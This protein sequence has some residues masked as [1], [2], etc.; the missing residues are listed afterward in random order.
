MI[1][2]LRGELGTGWDEYEWRLRHGPSPRP[3]ALNRWDGTSL[4]GRS[5]LVLSEQG[6]GDQVMFGSCLPQV[7]REAAGCLV[8]CDPRLVPLFARSFPNV[9]AVAKSARPT[10]NPAV[11]PCDVYDFWGSLPRFVRR[12]VDD[13]PATAAYLK[14]EPGLVAKWQSRLAR[15][16][17]ALKVGISWRG[18]KDAETRRQRSIP[19][20]LWRPIL[21][22]PGVR[23][24]NLQY[25]SSA[26]EAALVRNRFDIP[27]DDGA[28][29]DPLLDLD[30]FTAKIAALDLVLSVDNSTVHLA[31]A[32]G[33][34][35]WTLLPFCSDWR[36]MLEGETTPWYPTMRLLRCRTS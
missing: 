11:A 21:Q 4:A 26:A 20:E 14:P 25:G 9:T 15:L 28:D 12:Q 35:V 24:V 7:A 5:L 2:L 17:G 3:I 22:V 1:H 8:E 29:C 32:I 13:F 10:E 31:A 18:G 6:I 27:L 16:G 23:F 33:R 34:S 19:L 30:D 36:W